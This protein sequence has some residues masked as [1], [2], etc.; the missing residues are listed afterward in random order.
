ME[1]RANPSWPFSVA[2]ARALTYSRAETQRCSVWNTFMPSRTGVGSGN[3][4][5]LLQE[6][7]RGPTCVCMGVKS[8]RRFR[9]AVGE[10][11]GNCERQGFDEVQVG[12]ETFDVSVSSGFFWTA[13]SLTRT[14]WSVPRRVF[15]DRTLSARTV[16]QFQ[17]ATTCREHGRGVNC[18]CELQLLFLQAQLIAKSLSLRWGK[19]KMK[20][21]E[22]IRGYKQ[23]HLVPSQPKSAVQKQQW[24]SKLM[25]G[26]RIS[27]KHILD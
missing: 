23:R 7:T 10:S 8:C 21:K 11:W 22:N 13:F 15:R 5:H 16:L 2:C 26:G 25:P 19:E 17:S 27:E 1:T 14:W 9:V 4:F 24:R 3:I 20:Q 6:R 12:K 18:L